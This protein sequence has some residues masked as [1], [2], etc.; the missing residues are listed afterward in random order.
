M[1]KGVNI[2][3][4]SVM[5]HAEIA[6]CQLN[7]P[8]RLKNGVCACLIHTLH[9]GPMTGPPRSSRHL[10]PVPVPVHCSLFHRQAKDSEAL[11]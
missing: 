10:A 1:P 5:M 9:I 7:A 8:V 6:V 4:R 3:Q 11:C 2:P